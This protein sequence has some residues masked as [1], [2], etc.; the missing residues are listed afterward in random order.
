MPAE[1]FLLNTVSALMLPRGSIFQY[2][3]LGG[4]QFKKYLKKVVFLSK[5]WRFIQE[6]PQILDFSHN[7]GLYS[8]VGQHWSGYG[9]STNIND[10]QSQKMPTWS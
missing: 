4:G 5:K 3:F 1:I 6:K 8:R 7:L 2:G 10:K 9:I